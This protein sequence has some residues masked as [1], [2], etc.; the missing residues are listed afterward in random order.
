MKTATCARDRR[1]LQQLALNVNVKHSDQMVY[2]LVKRDTSI[3]ILVLLQWPHGEKIVTG[4]R[5]RSKERWS[6]ARPTRWTGVVGDPKPVLV[7]RLSRNC[8]NQGRG[9]CD[10]FCR[11]VHVKYPLLLIGKSVPDGTVAK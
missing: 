5:T 4:D 11:I 2:T 8:Y 3:P 6:T 10:S 1:A 7:T 9:M